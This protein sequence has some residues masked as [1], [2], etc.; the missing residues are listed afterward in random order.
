MDVK[1]LP[2][3]FPAPGEQRCHYLITYLINQTVAIDAGCLGYYGVPADQARVRHVFVS[4]SHSDHTASLPVFL[5]NAF[6]ARSDCVVVHG[7]PAVLESL[8]RDLFNDR[9]WPDF[10]ALSKTDPPFIKLDTLVS[11]RVVEFE[12][13]RI[14]PI[15]VNHTVPTHGF[16]IE[17]DHSGVLIA[18]D[19]G[20]T[21][22]LWRV[23]NAAAHLDAVFLEAAFPNEMQDLA[24]LSKHLTPAE[25]AG[26]IQKMQRP[27]KIFA[28]HLKARFRDKIK[29]ELDALRLHDLAIGEFDHTYSF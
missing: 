11:G 12:G 16:L 9:I 25:F 10:I 3:S 18:S 7:G 5:E 24:T 21:D 17:D 28:V 15:E 19:T 2:S 22:E 27:V 14:T 6:E 29:A 4:H 1:L 20:P 23:A 13:L 26:E 8:Q